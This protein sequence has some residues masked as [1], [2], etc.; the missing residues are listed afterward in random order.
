MTLVIHSVLLYIVEL[1]KLVMTLK[2]IMG[3]QIQKKIKYYIF[4]SIGILIIISLLEL[5]ISNDPNEYNSDLYNIIIALVVITTLVC[6]KGKRK[7]ITLI[8]SYA[9]ITLMDIVFSGLMM[10]LL[11]V[12][13]RLVIDSYI[14]DVF[15]N[16]LSII[17]IS[18]IIVAKRK[19]KGS[20]SNSFFSVKLRYIILCLVGI[21]ASVCYIV[22]IQFLGIEQKNTKAS[23]FITFGVSISGIVFIVVLVVL[24][25]INDSRN[26][27]RYLLEMN[28][29]LI[30]QQKLYYQ[31]L[32]DKEQYTKRFR[33][34]MNNH[35][36]CMQHLCEQKKFDELSDYMYDM[37]NQ[38]KVLSIDIQTG[39]D[40][41]NIIVND[42]Y[43]K[44]KNNGIVI[45]WKGILPQNI[46]ISMMDLCTIFSN[47]FSNAIEAVEKIN[48]KQM[49]CIDVNIKVLENNL[50]IQLS[51]PVH[52]QVKLQNQTLVTTKKNKEQ[53]GLG[54]VNVEQC[55]KKYGG[56]IRYICSEERFEVELV[57]T[58]IISE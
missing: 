21:I 7:L 8:I 29:K 1:I 15:A 37:Q 6:F 54:S 44:H 27:Y 58:D 12:Q 34:D 36:I 53:H 14:L 38:M 20:L 23:T 49:R 30:E 47:L 24:L 17:F 13:V 56:D 18:F 9:C 5:M 33:H 46:K 16:L 45:Q 42:I 51:N 39:N 22:P 26:Q 55:V 19:I 28:Q 40:V 32:I 41:V 4:S 50:V 11:N 10:F 3:F 48:N 31:T 25:I 35:I 2:G 43:A 57:F 52:E